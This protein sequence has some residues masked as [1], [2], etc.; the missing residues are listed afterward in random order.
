ML[1]GVPAGQPALFVPV[2]QG[3]RLND[4]TFPLGSGALEEVCWEL[5]SVE[6]PELWIRRD[7]YVWSYSQVAGFA[8]ARTLKNGG[9]LT[10][11]LAPQSPEEFLTWMQQLEPGWELDGVWRE[12]AVV[13]E[14]RLRAMTQ[15]AMQYNPMAQSTPVVCAFVAKLYQ[16]EYKLYRY[17]LVAAG[18][19]QSA[20]GSWTPTAQATLQATVYTLQVPDDQAKDMGHLFAAI[21]QNAV[22]NPEWVRRV[23]ARNRRY[24]RILDRWLSRRLEAIR[25]E[26]EMFRQYMASRQ[27]EHEAFMGTLSEHETFVS[28]TNEAWA[29]ILGEKIYA[30]DP[31]TGEVFIWTT[32]AVG[33]C[34]IR[35]PATS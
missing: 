31:S 16:P 15:L 2:P 22:P 19:L 3:F 25:Q 32:S 13:L 18:G 5:S 4:F 20:L 28:D 30:R 26:G 27:A 8:Q 11:T 35:K 9:E 7:A 12:P 17:M 34:A 14:Q 24:Q 21:V 23:R 10:P 1:E 29:D 33:T 6:N